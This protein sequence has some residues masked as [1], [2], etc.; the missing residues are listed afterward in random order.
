MDIFDVGIIGGGPGGY[1][2]A[3]KSGGAGL[4]TVVFEEK[5]MGGVCLNEGCIPSKSLLY[6][7]KVLSSAQN[8]KNFGVIIEGKPSIDQAAII[9][10]KN[11]VVNRLVLGVKASVKASGALTVAGRAKITAK[12][13]EGFII[14]CKGEYF[15]KNV[16]VATGSV[17]L[18]PSIKGVE[19]GLQSG[20]VLTNREILNLTELPQSLA[21]LGGGVIGLEMASYYAAAGVPVKVIE[22]LP[23]I[24][25]PLDLTIA[26]ALQKALEEKGIEFILSAK[27]IEVGEGNIKYFKDGQEN[28][29][30]CGKVLL[31][32]G[33][34]PNAIGIGLE[35]LGVV[36][37]RGN[38]K[39]DEK[40]QTNITGVYAVGDCNGKIML[41]HAAAREAE[42]AV[43]D[44][45][46]V[47]DAMKYNAIPSVIYSSPEVGSVGLT[48]EQAAEKGIA[49]DIIELPLTYS[50]RYV[51][52]NVKMR[53]IAK[54]I[55]DKK[56]NKLLGFHAMGDYA[57]EFIA[58]AGNL[59]DLETDLESI[60]HLVFPHPT[61]CEIFKE[62]THKL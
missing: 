5:E 40:M 56:N 21:V 52:E 59:I 57:S 3:Q 47:A 16:I 31:S 26:N 54:A 1:T 37:G 20:F 4:K 27:V 8:A 46:G 25:N 19:E 49:V 15:C 44:I 22:M 23:R 36:F 48:Q 12:Q 51:A 28:R 17:S 24:A 10:R 30:D 50:G 62:I 29:L 43:N 38:V 13:K 58:Q 41:A 35:E 61:V 14:E 42:V 33:R 2:A 39:T 11:Q 53:G 32:V 18:I 9:R 6:S 7:A 60:K 55:V 45:L 34:R